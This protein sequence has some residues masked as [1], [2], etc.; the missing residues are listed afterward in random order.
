MVRRKRRASEAGRGSAD[1]T[2]KGTYPFVNRALLPVAA[3]GLLIGVAQQSQGSRFNGHYAI[4]TLIAIYFIFLALLIGSATHQNRTPSIAAVL[5]IALTIFPTT[6]ALKVLSKSVA[7]LNV[8]DTVGRLVKPITSVATAEENHVRMNSSFDDLDCALNLYGWGPGDFYI[9]SGVPSC[10]RH[11]LSPLISDSNEAMR[12]RQ[13]LMEHPPRWIRLGCRADECADHSIDEFETLIFP[14]Q[15]AL[16][17]CYKPVAFIGQ[18][19][20][21]IPTLFEPLTKSK[22]DLQ[23]CIASVLK[24]TG[25]KLG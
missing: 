9:Y 18:S 25:L 19:R 8:N 24:D 17:L 3:T 23:S 13:E 20:S 16:E 21:L 4:T 2:P 11:F 1:A 10:S 14:T 6:P 5:L 7:H 22:S 15:L 12:F